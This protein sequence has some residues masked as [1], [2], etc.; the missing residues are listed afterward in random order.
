MGMVEVLTHSQVVQCAS[1]TVTGCTLRLYDITGGFTSPGA[2]RG[3]KIT[4]PCVA[5]PSSSSSSNGL[6]VYGPKLGEIARQVCETEA[7]LGTG[8]YIYWY[9]CILDMSI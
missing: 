5:P 8:L 7:H 9:K 1:Y 3:R 6:I 2:E 4:F